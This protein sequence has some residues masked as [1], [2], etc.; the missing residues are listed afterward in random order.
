VEDWLAEGAALAA[1]D[2]LRE[3]LAGCR[4]ADAETGGAAVGPHRSDL[5]VRHLDRDQAAELCSTGEQKA[6][7]IS[8]VLAHARLIGLHRGA[9]PLLLLDEVAAHLDAA[10]RRALYDEILALGVQAWMTGTD[11]DIFAPLGNAAQGY[12]VQ[13]SSLRPAA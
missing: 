11:A 4:G 8:I 10:R 7:L 12:R 6:L 2:R 3:R 1:E 13:D 9:A 5:A